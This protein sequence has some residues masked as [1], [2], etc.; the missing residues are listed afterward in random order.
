MEF[1]KCDI[2]GLYII[3]PKIFGDNRGYF[4]ET[5]KKEEF[6][7]NI[8][9]VIW[10]QENQSK[11]TK[12]VLR[13]LHFQK[14]EFSQA[15]LVRVVKGSVFDVAVDL[16]KESP[17]YG[18]YFSV[19]LSEDNMLQFYIPRGFAHGFLVLSDEAVFEYKVDN[20]YLPKVEGSLLWNDKTIN[21]DWPYMEHYLLS[22]KDKNAPLLGDYTF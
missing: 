12:G 15:K 8:G 4:C 17:T 7:K 10:L 13:G 22:E 5:Y 16:R 2:E 1:I 19:E 6:E 3:K 9:K 14:G 21:I 20:I 11:S 18:Q